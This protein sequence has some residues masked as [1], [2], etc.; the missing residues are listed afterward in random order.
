MSLEF[1]WYWKPQIFHVFHFD[2]YF[3]NYKFLDMFTFELKISVNLMKK[4]GLY[5]VTMVF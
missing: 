3:L 5:Y 1:L 2:F 4:H